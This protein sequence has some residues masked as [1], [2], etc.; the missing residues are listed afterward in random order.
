MLTNWIKQTDKALFEQLEWDK[1]ERRDQSGRLL[2]IGGHLH[3][4]NAPG[5]AYEYVREVGIG[6]VQIA[7]PSRVKSLVGTTLPGAVFLPSTPSGEFSRDG[8]SELIAHAQWADT[9]LVAGDVGRNSQTTM[10]LS[11]LL[12]QVSTPAVVTKDAIDA[13]KNTPEILL[14]R[15]ETTIV[16]SFSQIQAIAKRLKVAE[17][18]TFSMG[19]VKLVEQLT[20]LITKYPS[21][22][23]TLHQNTLLIASKGRVSTTPLSDNKERTWRTKTAATAACYQTWYPDK[24]LEA[25]THAAFLVK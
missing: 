3:N 22:I 2:I 19:V 25:L 23:V 10:L 18:F 24:P 5:K 7:L 12:A 8:L 15:K 6:S 4:L 1:P 20:E 9:I 21:N 14:G 16:A 17:A 13:L 11:D